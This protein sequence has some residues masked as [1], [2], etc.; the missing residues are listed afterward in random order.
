MLSLYNRWTTTCPVWQIFLS[1]FFFG[2]ICWSGPLDFIRQYFLCPFYYKNIFPFMLPGRGL[3]FPWC[4]FGSLP[5]ASLAVLVRVADHK[6]QLTATQPSYSPSWSIENMMN[7]GWKK[8]S[9]WHKPYLLCTIQTLNL[10]PAP[11]K[12]NPVI[13]FVSLFDGWFLLTVGSVIFIRVSDQR[14]LFSFA[15]LQGMLLS[16]KKS[17]IR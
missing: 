17:H 2:V 4:V 7:W 9:Q 16:W 15:I 13:D 8:P 3:S 11:F 10:F 6:S 14:D 12:L 5:Y 1:F